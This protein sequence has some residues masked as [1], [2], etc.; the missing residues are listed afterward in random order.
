M[1]LQDS[2]WTGD[3]GFKQEG[4]Q[5]AE[6]ASLLIGTN[7]PFGIQGL[8]NSDGD[9]PRRTMQRGEVIGLEIPLMG[10]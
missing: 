6:A 4:R 2:L 10:N 1:K 8:G 3:S 9:P 5:I 7:Q